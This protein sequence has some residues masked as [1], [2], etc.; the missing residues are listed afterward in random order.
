MRFT[1]LGVPNKHSAKRNA[2]YMLTNCWLTLR[3]LLG[4]FPN[5]KAICKPDRQLSTLTWNWRLFHNL[6]DFRVHNTISNRIGYLVLY[7]FAKVPLT[8]SCK[9]PKV[10]YF[11]NF[12][13][14]WLDFCGSLSQQFNIT[15]LLRVPARLP[16]EPEQVFD[17]LIA[18]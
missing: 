3:R 15:Y 4:G 14:T 16:K 1:G 13:L 5:F 11:Q 6:D 9:L 7:L 10:S 17:F 8:F 18:T 12:L 2:V